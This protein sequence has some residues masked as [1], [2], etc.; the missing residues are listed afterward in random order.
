LFSER[1]FIEVEIWISS[2]LFFYGIFLV[3]SKQEGPMK[4]SDHFRENA[5]NCALLAEKAPDEPTRNRYERMEAA[6]R[7]LA[8]EQDWLDGEVSPARIA[9]TDKREKRL[10]CEAGRG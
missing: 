10:L 7:A 4:Q 3:F 6:W 9:L 5:D 2:A 8:Q 1:L